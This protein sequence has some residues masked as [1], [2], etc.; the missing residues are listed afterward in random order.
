MWTSVSVGF[1]ICDLSQNQLIGPVPQGSQ[2]NTFRNDSFIG[3]IGLCG[4]PLSKKCKTDEPPPPPSIVKEDNDS[5]FTSGFG[6]K[7]VLM[8]YGFGFMFGSTMGYLML[9]IG[10]PE[11]LIRLIDGEWHG[12]VRRPNNQGTRPRRNGCI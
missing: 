11:L 10:K 6:W 12:K 2:F 3:N 9:K 1:V 5:I 7:A 4:F 8:G